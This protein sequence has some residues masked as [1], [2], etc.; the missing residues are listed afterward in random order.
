MIRTCPRFFTAVVVM[1]LPVAF[2]GP[3]SPDETP[4]ASSP[5]QNAEPLAAVP[6]GGDWR[7]AVDRIRA[8]MSAGRYADA[9]ALA[10][11]ES[12]LHA[13]IPLFD[14]T[15]G[16][17]HAGAGRPAAAAVYFE[18]AV[19]VEPESRRAR[20]ELARARFAAGDYEGAQ[21][22]FE[23]VLG[24]APPEVASR[25]ERYLAAIERR[26]AERRRRSEG[27]VGLAV[28]YD[29]NVQGADDPADVE[30]GGIDFRL[31]QEQDGDAFFTV[32]A[33]WRHARPVTARRGW[34]VEA[35]GDYRGNAD[36]DGYDLLT[37]GLSGGPTWRLEGRRVRGRLEAQETQLDGEGFRRTVALAPVVEWTVAGVRRQAGGRL[38]RAEYPEVEGREVYGVG[39]SGSLA[40]QLGKARR[41][42]FGGGSVT[43]ER[44]T[45]SD[46]DYYSRDIAGLFGGVAWV[47]EGRS[48]IA[49]HGAWQYERF[50]EEAPLSAFWGSQSNDFDGDAE[51]AHTVR[52]G[53]RYAYTLDGGWRWSV[54]GNGT[55]KR[56]NVTLREYDRLEVKVGVRYG[57]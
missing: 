43:A 3:P 20:L 31:D 54:E 33:G 30:I 18:R 56:S 45:D 55:E 49:V 1:A 28:G 46:Y 29:T 24:E 52:V 57:W 27:W 32:D 8:E 7:Q 14:L 36:V 9:A 22:H 48:T 11:A 4:V 21:R 51:R 5:A 2:A 50:R 12:V 13:G 44:A 19:L 34:E 42:V 47:P 41:T 10:D 53:A 37:V 38:Y 39:F 26:T 6:A 25:I 35:R 15:G 23:R 17:A 16:L 40:R